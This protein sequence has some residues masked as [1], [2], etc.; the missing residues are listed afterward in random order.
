MDGGRRGGG[1]GR[2]GRHRCRRSEQDP[3]VRLSKALS[4]ALRH[5]ASQLGLDMSSDGFVSVAELLS[6]PQFR[7][8]SLA[9]VRRVVET[10]DKQ[11]FRLRPR[12]GDGR[13]EIRANQGHSV[14][15]DD[16]ELI[17]V[18]PGSDNVPSCA[19]HGTYLRHWESIRT[20][21]LSRMSRTHIHLSPGLPGEEGVVSGMRG[22]CSLAIFIDVSR[23]LQDGI[24]FFWSDN[25]VILTPGDSEGRLAPRYFARALRLTEPRRELPL[26]QRGGVAGEQLTTPTPQ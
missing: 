25:G 21:G 12:P 26:E 14:Q 3:D 15:V 1:G 4:F 10:N 22:D 19:V 16:L 6:R 13:L 24:P 11:R 20:R 7:A 17:P 18:V 5:G 2:G 8:Y 23:A 9:D